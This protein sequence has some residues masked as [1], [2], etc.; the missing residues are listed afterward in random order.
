M[1]RKIKRGWYLVTKYFQGG[2]RQWA[3]RVTHDVAESFES[4]RDLLEYLG[5]RTDGGHSYG[6]QIKATLKRKKPAEKTLRVNI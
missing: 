6:Y 5:E 1:K 3:F 2:R 4:W